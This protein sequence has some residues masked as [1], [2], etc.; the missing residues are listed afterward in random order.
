MGISDTG[1]HVD[2][3]VFEL[4]R[5]GVML[6]DLTSDLI[7]LMPADAYPGEQPGEVVLEMVCGT[8]RSVLASVDPAEVRRATELIDEAGSRVIEH[9]ELAY[10]LSKRIQADGGRGRMYG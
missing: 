8:I 9:L 1:D 2:E 3:F 4:L 10:R 5:T 7:E 6:S